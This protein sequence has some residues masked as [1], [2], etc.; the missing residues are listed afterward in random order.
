PETCKRGHTY[1]ANN[2]KLCLMLLLA[3]K[4]TKDQNREK[5]NF[6][7]DEEPLNRHIYLAL[8]QYSLGN[9][10]A[11]ENLLYLIKNK[12]N[13]NSMTY[14]F[15]ELYKQLSSEDKLRIYTTMLSMNRCQKFFPNKFP[16]ILNQLIFSLISSHPM[17][18]MK[19]IAKMNDL[20][21]CDLLTMQHKP[22]S[23]DK[24]VALQAFQN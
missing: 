23:E 6:Q 10:L 4:N 19:I 7:P 20:E 8:T 13:H 1:S 3:A 21:I 15:P 14:E 11:V 2:T 18:T 24:T 17:I 16:K 22:P 9:D 12:L 5:I